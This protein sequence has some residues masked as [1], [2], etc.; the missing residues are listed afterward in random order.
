MKVAILGYGKMGK[1]IESILLER[2]HEISLKINRSNADFDLKEL[3]ESDVAIEFSIPGAATQN[4]RKCF[5][6]NVPVVVGTTAWYDDFNVITEECKAQNQTLFYASNF[7]LGVNIFFEINRKLAAMMNQFEDYN[8]DIDEIHHT[9]KLDAPS[10]TAITTAEVILKELDR[11][12]NWKLNTEETLSDIKITAQRIPDVPGT[13][14]VKYESEIDVISFEHRA[15]SRKGFALGS[16]L[17]AEFV[18]G[19]KGI[20]GMKDLLNF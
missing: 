6:A 11:K 7:S 20:F 2:G 3:T 19:K 8:V 15:K 13:H 17:A 1:V 14:T 9:Q 4:I 18:I 12:K 16:V 10:G 5:Q